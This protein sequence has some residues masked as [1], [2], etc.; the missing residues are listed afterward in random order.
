MV[1]KYIINKQKIGLKLVTQ[2]WNHSGQQHMAGA[3][4]GEQVSKDTSKLG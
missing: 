3:N 4:P 1:K 2:D